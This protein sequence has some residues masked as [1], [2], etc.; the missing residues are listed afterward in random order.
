[1]SLVSE[2]VDC[3]LV[4]GGSVS[5]DVDQVLANRS[6]DV[7]FAATPREEDG[8][9]KLSV[10]LA[11]ERVRDFIGALM[12]CHVEFDFVF[13]SGDQEEWGSYRRSSNHP[14][15]FFVT[16]QIGDEQDV[17]YEAAGVS[18]PWVPE[19][20][21]NPKT[22]GDLLASLRSAYPLQPFGLFAPPSHF[23]LVDPETPVQKAERRVHDDE[24]IAR[25]TERERKAGEELV[26]R[27]NGSVAEVFD[28]DLEQDGFGGTILI[29]LSHAGHAYRVEMEYDEIGDEDDDWSLDCTVSV[30]VFCDGELIKECN[31]P[32]EVY[33]VSEVVGESICEEAWQHAFAFLTEAA[34]GEPM[35]Y[36]Q[37][38]APPIRR[39]STSYFMGKKS[40]IVWD[41]YG[42]R[43]EL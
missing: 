5:D 42:G 4:V 37:K 31:S 33:A 23:E 15:G 7:S 2:A 38:G 6:F 39:T 13:S 14:A 29:T 32:E 10:S 30:K 36:R 41:E 19:G 17:D 9:V 1:M 35:Y 24:Q 3:K 22:F 25:R 18:P 11:P 27:W 28:T 16:H 20:Q 34:C 21:E 40:V 26:A 12:D 8:T 43:T